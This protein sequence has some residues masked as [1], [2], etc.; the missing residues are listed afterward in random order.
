MT[1]FTTHDS[2][3][4]PMSKLITQQRRHHARRRF[5]RRRNINE[6]AVKHRLNRG[7]VHQIFIAWTRI[8]V[9]L[10]G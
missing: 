10:D 2:K 7:G 6:P 5:F 9:M 1:F 4:N 3:A 8:W